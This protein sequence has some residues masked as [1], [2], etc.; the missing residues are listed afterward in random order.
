VR[1]GGA[2]GVR[3]AAYP[4]SF[5]PP[6]VAHLAIA[7]AALHAAPLDRVDWCVSRDALGKDRRDGPSF[8]ERIEVLERVAATRAWLGVVITDARLI[9]DVAEGYDV[10]V[11]GA[12]KWDQVND[13]AW[14]ESVAARDAA[15]ARLP[16]PL[17]VPR[18]GHHPTGVELLLVD[19]SLAHVSSTAARLGHHDLVLPEA[20][21]LYCGT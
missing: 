21:P 11:M 2:H 6:T 9:V 13:P 3:V 18:A 20:R 16:R 1:F 8:D 19:E 10:V 15:L 12:D 14:Y 7:Q 17:V 4:G 5:D